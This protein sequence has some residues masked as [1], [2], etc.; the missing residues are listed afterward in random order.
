[1]DLPKRITLVLN[2]LLSGGAAR[3]GILL[4]GQWEAMGRTICMLTMDDGLQ[5]PLYRL[6]PTIEHQPLGLVSDSGSLGAKVRHNLHCLRRLR[7]A[8][9]DSRP[10]ILISFLDENNIRC[11]LATRGM[12]LPAVVREATDPHRGRLSREWDLLRRLTYPWASCVITQTEHAMAYFSPSVRRRG[13]VI[14]NPVVLPEGE[15]D[16]RA[17]LHPGKGCFRLVALGRLEEVKGFGMLLDAFSRAA[18]GHPAWS[19]SIYGEGPRRAALQE[20]IRALGLEDRVALPGVTSDPMSRLREADLFVL[21]SR[22]EGFPNALAEAMAC[23]LP[24]VSFNCYSG[25]SELIRPGVDG[26]LVPPN[27]VAA[28]ATALDR[29]M[30]DP[31]ERQRMGARAPDVLRRF[32]MDKVLGM[33]EDVFGRVLSL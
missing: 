20:Q 30:G 23:G 18:P 27:D 29:L 9:T 28:L 1:M 19:L 31:E 2:H 12:R 10:D 22:F 6:S 33:W 13:C 4:A 11:L 7:Q 5:E 21:S 15:G 8:I 16:L 3:V 25:P 32:S 26:V 17:D 24:V 14:P